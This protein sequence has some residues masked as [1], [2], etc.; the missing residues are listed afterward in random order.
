MTPVAKPIS[1]RSDI[2]RLRV[3]VRGAVQGVGFRPFVY[4]LAMNLGLT[5]WVSNS[6]QGVSIEVEGD[7][8]R[9]RSFLLSI[10]SEKPPRSFIQGM[11][12]SYLD[13]IGFSGFQIRESVSNGSKTAIVLPDIATCPDCIREIFDPNDRRFL[14]PFT[15]CTNC[16]PRYSIIEALPYDRPNTTMKRFTMCARCRSEYEDPLNRRFHA[17]PNACPEC[18]PRLNFW[19][20][21]GNT[22]ASGADALLEAANAIRRG[23]IVAVKGLGGFHLMVDAANDGSVNEL[24]KR[25][26]RE[27]KPLALMYPS[28]DAIDDVCDV[29]ELEKRSI[30]SP[31]R[32]IVILKTKGAHYSISK[33]VAPDNPYLGCMLPYTPLHYLLMHELGFPVVATSGNL[34][35]E[36][37]CIDENEALTRLSRIAD[38]FL[39]HD[40]PI[41]RHVDD[42]I[43]RVM[44]GRES[45]MR[46]ARGF[47]PL[48][49]PQAEKTDPIL[50]VGAH[51]KN[52][53]AL[54]TGK[55]SFVSQHIGDLETPEAFAAFRNVVESLEKLY[56]VSPS[57]IACDEHPDYLSTRFA[58]D[59]NLPRFEVQHHYAHILSCMAENEI[60]PPVLGIAWDGTGFGDDGT[61]WGGEFLKID[62]ESFTREAKFRTFPLPGG[63]KAVRQPRRG[64]LG[65]LFEQFGD[66]VFSMAELEPVRTFDRA[67]L[68]II[69]KMLANRVNSPLTSSVGR[70]FDAV[71]SI[72]GLRHAVHFEGQAAMEL[73]FALGGLKTDESYRC[74]LVIEHGR[75]AVIDWGGAISEIVSDVRRGVSRALISARFHNML[76]EAI[77]SVAH[78]VG[79][80]SVALSG[81]CFQNKYLLERAVT[82]LDE[83]GF[84]PYWHQRV[85]TND[86]GIALGQAL[87]AT[88][89]L[90]VEEKQKLKTQRRSALCA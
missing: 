22:V 41:V 75:P 38:L 62:D 77:V 57:V 53:V 26:H 5:G 28:L 82:R 46:R 6:P 47:A 40:R 70:L 19:D 83:E 8:H 23:R 60:E 24:R 35:D 14:Y 56:G 78:H 68:A 66:G 87:A 85:P 4:R 31:E 48:P 63:E 29:S 80:G 76:A 20:A 86:G 18:G 42:S 79:H 16:G 30:I 67:E 15:N 90:S 43:V 71:A 81:G 17:Q 65:V 27:E 3:F 2:Q 74:D 37:I 88:R 59:T 73:E 64:A 13:A 49:I 69:S 51:L 54:T 89:F 58:R 34:S 39:V 55:Q 7:T 61:I 9:L 45:V 11:E 44:A 52:A 84:R 12:S 72:T 50:A 33:S 10:E 25:K 1:Q 32:P 21:D 36:P